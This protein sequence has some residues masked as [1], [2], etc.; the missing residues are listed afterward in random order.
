MNILKIGEKIKKP[1]N[2]FH[3]NQIM[4]LQISYG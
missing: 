3:Q 2:D 4:K 1:S